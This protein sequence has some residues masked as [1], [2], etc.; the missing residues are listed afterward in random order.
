MNDDDCAVIRFGDVLLVATTDFVNSH[1][2]SIELGI[3]SFHTVG[4]LAVAANLA[5]LCG[6]GAAPKIF[7]AAVTMPRGTVEDDFITVMEGMREESRRWNVPIAGGDTKLGTALAIGGAAIGIA[8]S[9]RNLFLKHRSRPGDLVW[10][11]GQL[12]S[13]SAAVWGLAERYGDSHWQR[14]AIDTLTVP[15]L[16][17]SKSR[18]VSDAE[19]GRGGTDISDGLGMDLSQLCDCSDLGVVVEADHVPVAPEAR[20]FAVDSGLPPW[21][22]AFGIGGE[23]Q[24][25]VTTEA[26]HGDTMNAMGFHLIGETTSSKD[27]LLRF[28]GGRL[29]DFPTAGH[30]DVRDLTFIQE[31]RSLV[32]AAADVAK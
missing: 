30:R 2:I 10:A 14:W 20:A 28:P 7:L 27:R 24:F 8:V 32:Q 16:P 18:A 31:T 6:S 19:L 9:E 11:S 26:R 12:G 25:L 22:L 29:V 17:L 3:G 4:R 5:D 23:F 1:P 21:A 15:D 13:C